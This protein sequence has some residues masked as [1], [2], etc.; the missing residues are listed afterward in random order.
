MPMRPLTG[1]AAVPASLFVKFGQSVGRLTSCQLKKGSA[2]AGSSGISS[3][4]TQAVGPV[5]QVLLLVIS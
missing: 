2:A 1:V 4:L 3:Q 5:S